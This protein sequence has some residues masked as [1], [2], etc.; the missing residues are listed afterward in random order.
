MANDQAYPVEILS[1]RTVRKH[2]ANRFADAISHLRQA[3][4]C[5]DSAMEIAE[6][7]DEHDGCAIDVFLERSFWEYELGCAL[8]AET[9]RIR[10]IVMRKTPARR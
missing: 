4:H 6:H 7:A 10:S 9:E 1:H 3:Q 5:L 8:G 2:L